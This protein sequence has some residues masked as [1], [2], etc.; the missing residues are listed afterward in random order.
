MNTPKKKLYV[1][2][3]LSHAPNEFIQ[4]VMALKDQL[5]EHFEVLDFVGRDAGTSK[6]VFETDTNQVKNCD[7]F[8]AICD[9]PSLGL[10]YEVALALELGKPT[11]AVAHKDAEVSRMILGI[12][13]PS[14]VF[15]RY[16][17]ISDIFSLTEGTFV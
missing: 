12:N 6:E 3:S 10:G 9:L 16:E 4:H 15:K 1:G 13:K 2:C 11:L 8:L 17:N 5:R 14:F 7:C